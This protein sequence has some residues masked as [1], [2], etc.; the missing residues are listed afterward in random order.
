MKKLT[1]DFFK[2]KLVN[3]K[4][5]TVKPQPIAI[6]TPFYYSFHFLEEYFTSLTKIDYPKHLISLYFPVQGEDAT[7]ELVENFRDIYKKEYNSIT[8]Q[9]RPTITKAAECKH[10]RL[11]NI[12]TQRN[13]IL[14]KSKPLDLLFIGHDNFPPPNIVWRML[15]SKELG[16]DIAGGFYAFYSKGLAFTSFYRDKDSVH[17]TGLVTFKGKMWFPT[18]MIGKRV[19]SFTTGMDATF[20]RRRVLDKIVFTILSSAKSDDVEFCY[21][22]QAE[23]FKVLTDYA[24]YVKHWGYRVEFFEDNGKGFTQVFAT[25]KPHM[26]QRRK[27]L[28]QWRDKTLEPEEYVQ[29]GIRELRRQ[30]R[31]C[32]TIDDHMA[33]TYM[34]EGG[35][36]VIRPIQAMKEVKHL[37][38]RLVKLKAETVVEIGTCRGGTLYLFCKFAEPHATIISVDLPYGQFGGGY[39]EWRIPFYKSFAKK[40]QHL[41]LIRDDSHTSHVIEQVHK[42]LDGREI[43]FLFIDGDHTYQGVKADFENYGKLVRKGGIIAFHD[44][45]HNPWAPLCQVPKFWKELKPQYETEEFIDD[46]NQGGWGVGVI[47]V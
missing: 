46:V 12:C 36:Q 13:W 27:L 33:L 11:T 31:L 24:L 32:T 43:D 14:D 17:H 39:P 35:G 20:I 9:K 16:A 4:P 45:L 10:A 28:D 42:I 6:G 47:H 38:Q 7:L 5:V 23:R 19:W 37:L 15:E 40:N 29:E 18:C 34:F 8:V 22:A 44:I 25:M 30:S 3:E 2:E 21:K 26:L 1:L 41:H